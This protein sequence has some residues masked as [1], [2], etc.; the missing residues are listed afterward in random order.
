MRITAPSP[1]VSMASVITAN[2]GNL[3]ADLIEREEELLKAVDYG[4]QLLEEKEALVIELEEMKL[5]C[6]EA[7]GVRLCYTLY[8][9]IMHFLHKLLCIDA[10]FLMMSTMFPINFNGEHH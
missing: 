5:K 4:Q 2:C 10:L 8:V 9:Y 3:R 1:S 6:Q 7:E